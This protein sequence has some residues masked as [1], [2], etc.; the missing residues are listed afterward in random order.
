MIGNDVVDLAAAEEQS[1]WQRKGF[2][3]KVFT[4]GELKL[5]AA[6]EHPHQTVWLLWS[7]K[8]AAYKAHQRALN[9]PRKLNW[10][11]LNC[12]L[13]TFSKDKASGVVTNAGKQYYTTSILNDHFIYSSAVN[14]QNIPIKNAVFKASSAAM[15][16]LFQNKLAVEFGILP[17]DLKVL[18]NEHGMPGVYYKDQQFLS[19]VSFSDHGRFAAYSLSLMNCEIP[20][21]HY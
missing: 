11:A 20:V 4:T 17:Q 5:L 8:E 9:L 14:N 1:N 15:K 6:S 21:K 13:F 18:K 3:Q 2:L 16:S 12:E 10:Q 19:N 7:M